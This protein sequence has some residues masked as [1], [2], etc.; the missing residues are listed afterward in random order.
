MTLIQALPKEFDNFTSALLLQ[1]DIDKAKV[2]EAFVTEENNR[3]HR[4]I[5][6]AM[7]SNKPKL[8]PSSS[9]L[10][11]KWCNFV[12]V[13]AP[14]QLRYSYYSGNVPRFHIILWVKLLTLFTSGLPFL[15][16]SSFVLT[17]LIR[18]CR[19]VILS[20]CSI[21]LCSQTYL[22]SKTPDSLLYSILGYCA[23]CA[24]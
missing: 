4:M 2:I 8:S 6:S 12:M 19:L 18:K 17:L 3:R 1:K 11:P 9:S 10:P 23:C 20:F 15:L 5:Q 21:V 16:C 13:V 7:I 22:R 24:P 14:S